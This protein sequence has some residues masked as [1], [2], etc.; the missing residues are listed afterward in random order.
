MVMRGRRKRK[1]GW[2]EEEKVMR[3][4]NKQ[5]RKGERRKEGKRG[6]GEVE[7]GREARRK[8]GE[9]D[10]VGLT[11]RIIRQMEEGDR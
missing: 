1:E 5:E 9:K 3:E 7:V 4:G 11:E 2:G 10:R 6:G 8:E